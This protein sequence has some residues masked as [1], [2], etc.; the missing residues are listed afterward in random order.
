HDAARGGDVEVLTAD[1]VAD[2]HFGGG[3]LWW[4]RI[5][6]AAVGH[7]RLTRGGAALG[8]YDRIRRRGQRAERL[9]LGDNRDRV[10]PVSGGADTGIA[11]HAGEAVHAGLGLLDGHVV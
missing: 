1:R 5:E 3:Q 10:P 7:Q 2:R 8:H 11:A 6:V 4:H 9:R